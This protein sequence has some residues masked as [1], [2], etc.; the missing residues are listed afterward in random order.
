MVAVAVMKNRAVK[1]RLRLI[2]PSLMKT[3]YMPLGID[4]G[5][6][7]AF[8]FGNYPGPAF[9]KIIKGFG[10]RKN[11]PLRI[12]TK[13]IS[14]HFRVS[15]EADATFFR[16]DLSLLVFELW[17]FEVFDFIKGF[18]LRKILLPSNLYTG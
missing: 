17:A 13:K 8:I 6:A 16:I 15:Y 5:P 2:D 3:T 12:Y 1:L 10:L 11:C 7:P 9:S 4:R 18:G 14:A